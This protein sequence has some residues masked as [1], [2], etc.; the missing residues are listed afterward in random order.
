SEHAS[1]IRSCRPVFPRGCSRFAMYDKRA[2]LVE[3]SIFIV[4][5][6]PLLLVAL[7]MC[8]ALDRRPD[9]PG[10]MQYRTFAV[11]QS[12]VIPAAE[13]PDALSMSEPCNPAI[14]LP[15][16]VSAVAGSET[17]PNQL[18][19]WWTLAADSSPPARPEFR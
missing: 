17:S 19:H 16:F 15:L 18:S 8:M 3:T 2:A 13:L 10:L 12:G 4:R 14:G 1:S 9:P 7:V 6:L 11:S 5:T